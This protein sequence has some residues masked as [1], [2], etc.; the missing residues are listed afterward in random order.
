MNLVKMVCLDLIQSGISLSIHG[1]TVLV[2]P[3]LI[4]SFLVYYTVGRSPWTC[5]QPVTR[6]LPE[7]RTI[8][9]Q[10]KCI[11]TSI[12]RVGFEP[13]FPAFE[14]VKTVHVLDCT[15][16]LIGGISL[17]IWNFICVFYLMFIVLWHIRKNCGVTTAGHKQHQRSGIFCTVH[18]NGYAHNS[19]IRHAITK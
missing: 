7:H 1:S 10:N 4:F 6:L 14:W 11:K 5:D 2:G 8:K 18:A 17:P 9:T 16:T 19:G 12:P 13:T 15:A 3:C